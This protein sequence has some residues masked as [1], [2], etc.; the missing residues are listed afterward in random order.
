MLHYA[1]PNVLLSQVAVGNAVDFV[2]YQADA[3]AGFE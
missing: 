3:T 1:L 2:G